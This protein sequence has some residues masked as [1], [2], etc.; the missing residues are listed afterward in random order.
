MRNAMMIDA[1]DNVAV[2]IEPITKGDTVT[3]LLDGQEKQ[4][5]ALNDI[6]IYHKIA[7][8]DIPEGSPVVKYGEHIGVASC[9]IKAGEHVHEHNVGSH[10]ENLE[11]KA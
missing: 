11:E 2:V 3:Y 1:R 4:L 10:R 9:D 6:T 8:R 5:T 7:I